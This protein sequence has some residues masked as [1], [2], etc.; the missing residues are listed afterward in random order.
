MAIKNEFVGIVHHIHDAIVIPT[1]RG[2]F[3]K[4]AIVVKEDTT[5]YVQHYPFETLNT[6]LMTRLDQFKPGDKVKVNYEVKGNLSQK[7]GITAYTSLNFWRIELLE[8]QQSEQPFMPP[9]EQ[10]PQESR[11]SLLSPDNDPIQDDETDLPF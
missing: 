1:A 2:E 9:Q 4:R 8:S 10:T 3:H 6:E 7:D 11:A 5:E